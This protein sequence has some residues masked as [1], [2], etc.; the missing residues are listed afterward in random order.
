ME[1][2]SFEFLGM[3]V[4]AVLVFLLAMILLR[5]SKSR[6]K[7]TRDAPSTPAPV[8]VAPEPISKEIA[9]PTPNTIVIGTSKDAPMVT[10]KRVST[11]V[12]FG[13]V[14]PIDV[15]NKSAVSRLSPLLQA[16][17]SLLAAQQASG[18]H[19]MEV[20]VNG[21][22]VSAAD[23]N[24]LRAFVMGTDGITEHARLFEVKN[25]EN[26]IN[27]AAVWQIASVLVAQ[28]HLADISSKLDEIKK[29]VAGI[30]KFLDNQRKARISST[31]EYLGQIYT[32]LQGGE[33]SGAARN[34][35][36][37]CE[38]DLNEIYD[39]L[40]AEYRQKAEKKVEGTDFVGSAELCKGIGEKLDDLDLL[41]QDIS[42]CLK[43]RIAAWHVLSLFPGTTLLVGGRR[44]SIQKSILTFVSLGRVGRDKIQA[45]IHSIDSFWNTAETLETRKNSLANKNVAT[46]QNLAELS[47]QGLEQIRRSALV[48]LE[49]NRTNHLLLQI[50]NGVIV[51]A[52]QM[53]RS[54]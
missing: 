53:E 7:V 49:A 23:G 51:G 50:E 38:R 16:V 12:E 20:V 52:G 9:E 26:L 27:A 33:L 48:M 25:L 4:V 13:A 17:P 45:E 41:A 14:K 22:L 40:V 42:V 18:K 35:L 28:K 8:A 46:V 30:S 39:H 24:G 19:L 32:A 31:Y 6:Q 21:N 43:T 34:Q 3:M 5:R 47:K 37:S 44:E 2:K 11:P 10:I 36:E 29:S 1:N 15:R 54:L